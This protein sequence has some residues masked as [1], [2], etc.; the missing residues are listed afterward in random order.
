[1]H[2][3]AAQGDRS[4]SL[5][6]TICAADS[7]TLLALHTCTGMQ[8]K[9]FQ[10]CSR[11]LQR[12]RPTKQTWPNVLLPALHA[13]LR[14]GPTFVGHLPC[15]LLL[16][17]LVEKLLRMAA[18]LHCCLGADVLCRSNRDAVTLWP[19]M[20]MSAPCQQ[21]GILLT[22]NLPPLPAVG[23]DS[24]NEALVLFLRPTF[25]LFADC[26]RLAALRGKATWDGE[27]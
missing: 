5:T 17:Q 10:E 23:F 8:L 9:L 4:G 16:L 21:A 7:A 24:L 26:V 27:P 14:L 12:T 20:M 19:N 15:L 2:A 18:Y 25:A 11:V 13:M 3:A 22:F 6:H 1:M